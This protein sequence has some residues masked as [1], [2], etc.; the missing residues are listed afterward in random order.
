[1]RKELKGKKKDASFNCTIVVY[2]PNGEYQS[3]I[4]KTE[5][6]NK[7]SHRG[8]AIQEMKKSFCIE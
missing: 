8:R 7:V 6:K 3:F 2:Y 1:M 4:G 5:G